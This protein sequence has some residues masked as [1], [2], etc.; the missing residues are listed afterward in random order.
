MT[1]E[2]QQVKWRPRSIILK[3]II[4]AGKQLLKMAVVYK[5]E[6]VRLKCRKK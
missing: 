4:Q 1:R 2:R 5:R 6:F 3:P